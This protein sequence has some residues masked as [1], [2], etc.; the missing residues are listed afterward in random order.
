MFGW[1]RFPTAGICISRFAAGPGQ[2]ARAFMNRAIESR[3]FS[4]GPFPLLC[5]NYFFFFLRQVS[6]LSP[7]LV[8]WLDLGSLQAP[9]PTGSCH[10]LSP[11][12][13][14]SWDKQAPTPRQANFLY[15]QQRPRVS[16][17]ARMVSRS[18]DLV[19]CPPRSPKVLWDYRREPPPA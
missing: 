6:F 17:L 3:K 18:P 5:A 19:I 7:R 2:T 15:F 4:K 14:S 9:P 8:Q 13:P 16:C 11:A 10:S 1:T 12:S